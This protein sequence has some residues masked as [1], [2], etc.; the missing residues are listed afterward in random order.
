MIFLFE[1]LFLN[2]G[3]NTLF[4]VCQGTWLVSPYIKTLLCAVIKLLQ[5][6]KSWNSVLV[7]TLFFYKIYMYLPQLIFLISRQ[8]KFQWNLHCHPWICMDNSYR[9]TCTCTCSL[10]DDQ[11]YTVYWQP[12]NGFL[13]AYILLFLFLRVRP[14]VCVQFLLTK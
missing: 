4:Q 1:K 6:D 7:W 8:W 12:G 11:Y 10:A 13:A 2:I 9:H 5:C 14:I 3:F